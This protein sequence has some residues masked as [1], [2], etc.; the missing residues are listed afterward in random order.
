MLV[1]PRPYTY[2]YRK[3]R[4]SNPTLYIFD[5]LANLVISMIAFITDTPISLQMT[6]LT[7]FPASMRKEIEYF[8]AVRSRIPVASTAISLRARPRIIILK[9]ITGI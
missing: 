6:T 1:D 5:E 3:P 4:Y 7:R 9:T 8:A 2:E